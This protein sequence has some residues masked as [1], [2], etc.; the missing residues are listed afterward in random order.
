V[1]NRNRYRKPRLADKLSVISKKKE[2]LNRGSFPSNEIFTRGAD[3]FIAPP[4]SEAVTVGAL[5]AR[6]QRG[7]R[8]AEGTEFG[9]GRDKSLKVG[10]EWRSELQGWSSVSYL[11]TRLTVWNYSSRGRGWQEKYLVEIRD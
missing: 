8:P 7:R 6:R 1:N 10:A 3:G 11:R 2:R 5:P 9:D 4:R